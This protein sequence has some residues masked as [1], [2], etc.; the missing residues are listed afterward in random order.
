MGNWG[1][2]P[3][4]CGKLGSDTNFL[5]Q[6]PWCSA[7]FSRHRCRLTSAGDADAGA[8]VVE[9]NYFLQEREIMGKLGSDTN[10]LRVVIDSGSSRLFM[11]KAD[12]V[13]LG[14]AELDSHQMNFP[15]LAPHGAGVVLFLDL[16]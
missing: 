5:C 7:R 3:I 4:S 13:T 6:L 10:F 8:R 9:K 16:G 2:T 12:D 14:L 15:V 11:L 1:Q